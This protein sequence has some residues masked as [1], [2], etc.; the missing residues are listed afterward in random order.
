MKRQDF[1][2]GDRS[3]SSGASLGFF[4][5]LRRPLGAGLS[6]LGSAVPSSF[7]LPFPLAF[8]FD[9]EIE[10]VLYSHSYH[11]FK[12]SAIK[13]EMQVSSQLITHVTDSAK[14]QTIEFRTAYTASGVN[15]PVSRITR[16][17][18]KGTKPQTADAVEEMNHV[19]QID[20]W[21]CLSWRRQ[22]NQ[23]HSSL[24]FTNGFSLA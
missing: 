2:L 13:V 23:P 18:S 17:K 21:F 6:A 16:R 22:L 11:V 7:A 8:G 4:A 15:C 12:H 5:G 19:I 20:H 14:H 24:L 1:W 3:G 9:M 10:S